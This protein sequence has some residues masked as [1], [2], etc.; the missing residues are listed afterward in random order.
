M[1]RPSN[2]GIRAAIL[3]MSLVQMST[4]GI[5]P[6]LSDLAA[7]FP[8]APAAV[9]QLLMTFPS[10][11]VIVFS[12]VSGW[13]ARHVAK[14]TLA[15][16]GCALV[17]GSGVGAF[18]LH[19]VIQ[20]LF[21][22]AAVMG[23]GVGLVV[24]IAASLVTDCF[25][26]NQRAAMMGMQSGAANAG[27]M[28]M[29]LLGG[30]LAALGW[31][32]NYLVYLIAL[33]GLVLSLSCLPAGPAA[34]STKG[35]AR[36]SLR[37]TALPCITAVAITILFNLVPANLSMYIAE[38]QLGTAA[39]A[40]TGTTLL[41]F[42][43]VAVA[44]AFGP[45]HRRLGSGTVMLGF[46]VL[47]VGLLLCANASN[48]TVLLVGSVICGGSISLVMPCMMLRATGDQPWAT[49]MA[50]AVVMGCSN[51]GAF[52]TPTLTSAAAWVF[53]RP[54]TRYRFLLGA[55]LAAAA[56]LTGLA[57]RYGIARRT[58]TTEQGTPPI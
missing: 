8:T 58:Q 10:L 29:A 54:D 43:G 44:A 2:G 36:L 46:S 16:V 12:V 39:H 3:S 35:E 32:W 25:Q 9:I 45:L 21:L 22:W 19:P 14:R 42:S 53:G 57:G 23:A 1:D 51:L 52:L 5:A 31:R 50:S 27:G 6:I 26:G 49:A 17:A 34:V 37:K 48:L 56:A 24:P 40:G 30:F 41:L 11:F 15:A 13:L 7:E 55:I 38:H 18:L 20:V 28:L 4:N 47:A 33:P